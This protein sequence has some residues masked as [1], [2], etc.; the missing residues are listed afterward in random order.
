M[1]LLNFFCRISEAQH[2]GVRGGVAVLLC[3]VVCSG[4]DLAL[5]D[6]NGSYWNFSIGTSLTKSGKVIWPRN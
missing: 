1:A 6:Q 4:D 3:A 5:M 2:L